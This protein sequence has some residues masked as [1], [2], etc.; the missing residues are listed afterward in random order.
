MCHGVYG[1]T[2]VLW[3]N[4]VSGEQACAEG[5]GIYMCHCGDLVGG[6]M[7]VL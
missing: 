7:Y 3:G 5:G 4:I 2:R 1:D 6:D